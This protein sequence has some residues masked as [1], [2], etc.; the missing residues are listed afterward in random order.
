MDLCI[1]PFNPEAVLSSLPASSATSLS[2]ENEAPVSDGE[3][4]NVVSSYTYEVQ[5]SERLIS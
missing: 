5:I 2:G 1:Y 3:S 4:E